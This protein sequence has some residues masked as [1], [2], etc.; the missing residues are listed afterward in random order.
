MP[1]PRITEER[2]RQILEAAAAVMAER[3][4]C[5]ARISDIATRIGVSPA[6]VLYY[7]PT[8]DALLAE[9]LAFRDQQFFDGV[10]QEVIDD[11]SATARLRQL[12]EASCPPSE[13]V[14]R[15]DSE[16]LLWLDVWTR[17][18]HDPD[19]S[20]ERARLDEMFRT[21]IT[22]IVRDGIKLG[23]FERV[24]PRRFAVTLSALIDGLAI[25]VLLQDPS[26]DAALMR[27]LCLDLAASHLGPG[28]KSRAGATAARRGR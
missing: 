3:G 19:L 20:A 11:A 27:D 8:K 9:A 7:F 4:V 16:W 2:R 22:E 24:D 21:T 6:L 10:A 1:R 12:I 13:S 17:S 23:E 15:T 25:Q 14:E 5:E 28:I 26:V 18:R